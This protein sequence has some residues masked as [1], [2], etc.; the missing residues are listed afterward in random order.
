MTIDWELL[1][2]TLYDFTKT[3][4]ELFSKTFPRERLYGFAFDCNS[5][6]GQVLLCANTEEDLRKQAE[7]YAKG[8]SPNAEAFRKISEKF[9]LEPSQPS[10][11]VDAEIDE[12]RWALGDWK[13]QGFESAAFQDGWSP[14]ASAVL[15]WC[16]DHDEESD[17][18][19]FMTPTQAE[20]M[21]RACRVMV[22]LEQDKAFNALNRTEDFKTWVADHDEPDEISWDRLNEVRRE[23]SKNQ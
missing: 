3:D 10:D 19:T 2:Q 5:E 22:R 8:D 18:E 15:N 12:L 6:Y 13:Y 21:C 4:I 11:D 7:K 23:M 14:H 1:E 20:F 17:P 9:G 16:L